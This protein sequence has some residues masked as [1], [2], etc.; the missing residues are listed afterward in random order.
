[1]R[2][3]GVDFGSKRI[4]LATVDM[5]ARLPE[6]RGVLEASGTLAKDAIAIKDFAQKEGIVEIVVGLP[7]DANGETKMSRIC[8]MFGQRIAELGLTVH[9]VDES[10][11]SQFAE[12]TMRDTGL[13]AA[14]IRKRVDAEAACRILERFLEEHGEKA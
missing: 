10:L 14:A 5:S 2:L 7:L 9:F 11:T 3:L 12:S 6:P 13:G 1:M 4:G 8:R